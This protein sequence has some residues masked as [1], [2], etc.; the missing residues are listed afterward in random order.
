MMHVGL[1]AGRDKVDPLFLFALID[2]KPSRLMT[3]TG[4]ALGVFHRMHLVIAGL[5]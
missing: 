3:L 5:R 1:R 2:N 4:G